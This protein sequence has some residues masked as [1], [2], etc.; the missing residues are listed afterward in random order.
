MIC[1]RA[2]TA[3]PAPRAPDEFPTD[4]GIAR[5]PGVGRA[6]L[7]VHL[8]LVPSRPSA[9]PALVDRGAGPVLRRPGHRHDDHPDRDRAR[10]VHRCPS[11]ARGADRPVRRMEDRPAGRPGRRGL[12]RLARRAGYVGRRG[13]AGAHGAGRGTRAP[14][15]RGGR[16]SR[17]PSRLCRH[18]HRAVDH[19]VRPRRPGN[20]RHE[21][22]QPGVDLL[23]ADAGRGH[24]VPGEAVPRRRHGASACGPAAALPR[25]SRRGRRRDPNRGRRHARHRR[26]QPRRLRD[27][28]APP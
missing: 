4:P 2:P 23:P 10:G 13:R 19:L 25:H 7:L 8:Q 28:R 20:G 11:R 15:G 9:A 22:F 3:R 18:R 1:C 16:S 14:L 5:H 17:S 27:L 12:P 21:R 6:L 26:V 24:R